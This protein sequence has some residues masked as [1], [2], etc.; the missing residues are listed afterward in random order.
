MTIPDFQ[1]IMLPF[2]QFSSDGKL[3]TFLEATDA[4]AK[5]FKLTPEEI[6]TPIPSEPQRFANQVG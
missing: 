5:E 1:T 3:H 4:L 6:D 2:L